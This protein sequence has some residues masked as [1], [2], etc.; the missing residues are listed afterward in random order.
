[1]RSLIK[2]LTMIPIRGLGRVARPFAWDLDIG[3][4]RGVFASTRRT[5]EP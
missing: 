2:T 4:A 1:M 5:R 3:Q